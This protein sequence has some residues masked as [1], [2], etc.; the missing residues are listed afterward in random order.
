MTD[1][2]KDLLEPA[3]NLDPRCAI[4]G[5]HEIELSKAISLKRIADAMTWRGMSVAE[6][7]QHIF[8]EGRG[9]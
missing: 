1:N 9:H 8:R 7:A 5:E 2:R 3:A 6:A 4:P